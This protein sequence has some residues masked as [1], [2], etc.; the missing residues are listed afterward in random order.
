MQ[1]YKNNVLGFRIAY[2]DHWSVVPA[3]WMKQFMGRA[4]RTSERLSECLAKGGQPFLVAHDPSAPS[5][6]A[7]PAVKCQA[8]NPE[9][10]A[11]VGGIPSI[12]SLIATQSQQAFPDFTVLDFVPQCLVAGVKGAR[13]VA[14][15]TVLNPEGEV[16][17]GKSEF[18]FL[19][20]SA[21]VFMVAV[22]ATSDPEVRPEQDLTNIVRSIRLEHA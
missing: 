14:S 18:Y 13:M 2:P 11:A 19:P 5:D 4:A 12:L 16:F 20:T 7:I 22:S 10:I 17:H 15:M 1:T 3:A 6:V 9:T 21:V 8:Y